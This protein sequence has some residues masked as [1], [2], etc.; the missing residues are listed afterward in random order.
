M[1]GLKTDIDGKAVTKEPVL[2][3]PS[4]ETPAK[5]NDDESY[6]DFG[7]PSLF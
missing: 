5:S 6:W 7:F 3:A 1:V 4:M 2:G